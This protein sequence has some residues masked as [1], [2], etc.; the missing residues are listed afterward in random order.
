M[1]SCERVLCIGAIRIVAILLTANRRDMITDRATII[2]HAD[3]ASDLQSPRRK[4]AVLRLRLA[5]A[6]SA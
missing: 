3:L 1:D 5:A 4:F 2:N 6:N